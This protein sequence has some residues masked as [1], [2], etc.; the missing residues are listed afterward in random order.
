MSDLSIRREL[1]D[2]FL[3]NGDV[4]VHLD[5][6]RDGVEVPMRLKEKHEV[7]L[8]FGLDLPV[9]I[10]EMKSTPEH[11]EAI[12][13]FK[14][15]PSRVRIPWHAVFAFVNAAGGG[16][17][18]EESVPQEMRDGVDETDLVP[19]TPASPAEFVV[20]KPRPK[21]EVCL[22]GNL[23]SLDAMSRKKRGRPLRGKI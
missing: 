9:P 2:H 1:F 22:G 13:S 11:L 12:L 7:V 4:F 10:M 16:C 19:V 23:F 15:V 8:Q 14:G 20:K 5:P 3:A 21:S 18:F 6:R 17:V